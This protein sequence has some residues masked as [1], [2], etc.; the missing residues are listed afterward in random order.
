VLAE[1]VELLTDPRIGFI[2]I[3]GVDVAPD[4]RH[5]LVF[6]SA[7]DQSRLDE[8]LKGLAAAAPRLRGAL[9][10]QIRTKYTPELEFRVDSGVIGG[11]KIDAILRELHSDTQPGGPDG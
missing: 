8:A 2:T 6:V 7:L 9:G 11:E 4:M 10:R 1:E 3:T 5:A